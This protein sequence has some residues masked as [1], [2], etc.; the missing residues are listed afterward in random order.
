MKKDW[1]EKLGKI[2]KDIDDGDEKKFDTSFKEQIKKVIMEIDDKI[3]DGKKIN[4]IKKTEELFDNIENIKKS[5]DTE[6]IIF[7][8]IESKE[9]LSHNIEKS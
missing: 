9:D 7:G 6:K 5:T 2:K 3:D 8:F 4:I 1:I